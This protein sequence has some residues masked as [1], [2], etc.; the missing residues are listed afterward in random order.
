MTLA[1]ALGGCA[2]GPRTVRTDVTAFNEWSTLPA[3][4]TYTFSRTLEWQN[5]LEVK[6]YEDLV[7]DELALQGF[8]LAADPAQANLVVTLRPSVTG[9]S[10][11]TRDRW[12]GSYW[13]GPF[14][15]YY[16]GYGGFGGFYGRGIGA[17][18]WP[19]YYGP[20]GGWDDAET[21]DVYHRRLELDIDSRTTPGRR[22]YEG[23]VENNSSNQS[24]AQVMPVLVRALFTDFPGNNGQTRRVDVPV[25]RP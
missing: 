6:N 21:I 9:T 22:Y 16:G 5:S 19:G 3:D 12:G 7:R 24:L 1:A 15:G 13:G 4:R 11:R 17:Y 14:G 25:Q 23:R 10:I 18:G 8:R 2:V 20:F